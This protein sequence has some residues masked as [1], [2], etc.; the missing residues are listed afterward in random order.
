METIDVTQAR[1]EAFIR[2][3]CA[4][5]SVNLQVDLSPGS[6]L[7][8]L[9]IKLSS[10]LHNQLRNDASEAASA[11]SVQAALNATEDTYSEAIDAIASNYNVSRDLGVAVEGRVKVQVATL[12]TYYLPNNFKLT[13]PSSGGVYTSTQTFRADHTVEA[14]DLTSGVLRLFKE[15]SGYY[16]LLPV[17]SVGEVN[18]TVSHNSQLA[19]DPSTTSLDSFVSA[20]AFGNFSSGR[21]VETDRQLI[22]RMQTGLSAKGLVSPQSMQALLPEAFPSLFNQSTGRKAILSVVGANDPELNRGRNT[23]F[24]ITPFGMADVYVRTSSSIKVST[25]PVVARYQSYTPPGGSSSNTWVLQ[26][27]STAAGFPTWFYD[28]VSLHYVDA[29]GVTQS[30][31]AKSV[32]FGRDTTAPNQLE[33][34]NLISPNDVAR[35]TKYQTC[36]VSVDLPNAVEGSPQVDATTHEVLVTVSYM[37]GIGEIQDFFLQGAQR[38]TAADYLIKAVI[39]CSLSLNLS[40]D[41]GSQQTPDET[42][43]QKIRQAICSYVNGLPF[44]EEV[45]VSRIVDICHNHNVRRVDLPV[46]LQGNVLLPSSSTSVKFVPTSTSDTMS[47]PHDTRFFPYGLSAKTSMFFI[48]YNDAG[49]L[50]TI[51]ISMS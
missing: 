8:E 51:N 49:G 7:S 15:G 35:F 18:A 6:V 43:K 33:G 16:F 36:V 50:D 19:L 27:D 22:A 39:P 40:L 4:Q 20:R 28:L 9:L 2:D 14:D 34:G 45:A 44:G 1:L 42:T 26:L 47:I 25:F 21:E 13:H 46:V 31:A 24:G 32:T 12:R 37:P 10:Q 23:T 41:R 48:D 30:A 29:S 11:T 38:V 17:K 3:Y 5:P